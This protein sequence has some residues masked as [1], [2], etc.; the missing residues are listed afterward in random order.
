MSALTAKLENMRNYTLSYTYFVLAYSLLAWF[1]GYLQYHVSAMYDS[2]AMQYNPSG[3]IMQTEYALEAINNG[4]PIVALKCEDGI[5]VIIAND[6]TKS[7]HRG[8]VRKTDPKKLFYV[9]EHICIAA[10]GLLFD[11]IKIGDICSTLSRQYRKQYGELIPVEHLCESMADILHKQTLSGTTRPLGIGLIVSGY[12]N[13]RGNQIFS[14]QPDGSYYS[15]IATALGKRSQQIRKSLAE[16]L[17]EEHNQTG[18]ATITSTA[19]KDT[20][21]VVN[22]KM[23]PKVEKTL[24]LVRSRV[25]QKFYKSSDDGKSESTDVKS[26]ESGTGKQP[27]N[28]DEDG[29]E[30]DY[31]NTKTWDI[32]V[33][34]GSCGDN[35]KGD[36]TWKKI[37]ISESE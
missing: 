19:N 13:M 6:V 4:S 16:M 22:G 20:Y 9:D 18:N 29:E 11:S 37:D 33:V 15:W 5:I 24:R 7:S 23:F 25:I 36:F 1:C 27:L 17:K 26:N 3:R 10:T 34:C 28:D 31:E 14:V 8:R 12:D 30:D 32:Q 2:S 35:G 21:S